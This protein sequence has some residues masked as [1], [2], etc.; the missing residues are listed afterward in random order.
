MQVVEK[1]LSQTI[2]E[3]ENIML[4][5]PQADCPVVHDKIWR[6]YNPKEI[7]LLINDPEIKQSSLT[8]G[9]L[10]SASTIENN[11]WLL[12]DGFTSFFINKGD[13]LYEVHIGV[14]PK[15]RGK[16]ALSQARKAIDFMFSETDCQKIIGIIPADNK[17]AIKF[18][19]LLGFG[20]EGIKIHEYERGG[21]MKCEIL[22][23]KK[24]Y[25]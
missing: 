19:R 8:E 7:N 21:D 15:E 9:E 4:D 17:A 22:S 18:G 2:V 11:V 13:G 5:M 16:I 12:G 10:D 24:E 1:N 23:L 6:S 25:E 3:A 20:S 14:A